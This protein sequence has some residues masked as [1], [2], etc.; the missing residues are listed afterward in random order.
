MP[1]L[2]VVF[3]PVCST[4]KYI[5]WARNILFWLYI[6]YGR[7]HINVFWVEWDDLYDNDLKSYYLVRMQK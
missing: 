6:F 5:L 2:V 3:I 1:L 4:P 7:K